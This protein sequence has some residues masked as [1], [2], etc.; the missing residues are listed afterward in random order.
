M[1]LP[2]LFDMIQYF[3]KTA[4]MV[5]GKSYRGIRLLLPTLCLL[6]QIPALFAQVN[7]LRSAQWISPGFAEKTDQ[8]P[9]VLF[10]KAFTS[11]KAVESAELI[12]TA[13]GIYDASINGKRVGDG[14]F[15]PGY[16]A[17]K[18]RLQYQTYDVKALLQKGGKDRAG[19]LIQVTV[20][21]GW[22]R[23]HFGNGGPKNNYGSDAS[24]LLSL[25]ITYTDGTQTTVNSDQSWRAGTGPILSSDLYDGETYDANIQPQN[26]QPVKVNITAFSKDNLVPTIGEAVKK[27]DVISAK[28]LL[29]DNVIDFQQ[30]LAGWVKFSVQ[31][32]KGD[33]V[34]IYH[35]ETLDKNGEFFT[36]NLRVAKATDT[37][38]LSG[39]GLETFEP[40]FT[41]HGFRYIKVSG[42][43]LTAGK[44]A[45][46]NAVV[47]GTQLKATGTFSCS[48]PKINQLQS[49]IEWSMRSNFFDIP[50]D[51]PQRSERLGWNE[52]A[53]VFAPTAS[54]L[55]DVKDFYRKWLFD[56]TAEQSPSGAVP[57]TV[58]VSWGDNT[59][60]YAGWGDAATKT[61]WT[62]YQRYG[63]TQVLKDQYNS[64]K[65]W[66][67]YVTSVSPDYLWKANGFG[68]WYPYG[69][70]TDLP[71][72]DQC[73][74][75]HSTQIMQQT[76][77]I[78]DQEDDYQKYTTLLGHI[79]T[80]FDKTYLHNIPNTQTAYVIGLHF[81]LLPK[82]KINNLVQLIASNNYHLATGFMGTPYLM[83]V[84]SENGQTELAYTLLYQ[85]GVPSWMYMLDKG[86][87]TMWE[88]WDAIQTNGDIQEMSLNHYAFGSIG[89]WL[90]EKVAGI[91]PAA[92]GYKKILIKPEPNEKLTWAKGSYKSSFGRI[93]SSWTLNGNDFALD[94]TI[95]PNT[96]AEID[97]PG[98]EPVF[99][100]PGTYH[101]SSVLKNTAEAIMDG[102]YVLYGDKQ[103]YVGRINA[104][105]NG[106]LATVDSF[107][108]ADRSK[109]VLK[110]KIDKHPEWDFE[111]QLKAKIDTPASVFNKLEK[112]SKLLV[113]SDIEGEFEPFRN[114]L[115]AN[116]VID[117]K[118]NWTFDSGAL[119]IAGDLFDRGKQVSQYLWLLYK[120]ESDAAAKGGSVHVI[121]GN[122]DIMNLGG[123]L[124]YVASVYLNNARLLGVGYE[125]F[126]SSQTELGRWLRSKNIA[127]KI[128][129]HLFVHGGIS[130]TLNEKNSSVQDINNQA[131]PYYDRWMQIQNDTTK[132]L[133]S[134][135]TSPFWYRGYFAE[136][137]ASTAQVD[138]TLKIFDVKK[139]IVGHTVNEHVASFY[140]GKVIGVDVD[141][142]DGQ[143][144]GLLIID[145]KFYRV[146]DKGNR[147]EL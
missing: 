8:R 140:D 104:T 67:D 127:E 22:W 143:H 14:Y 25:R 112:S 108:V 130:Q 58:P 65:A 35:A 110:V 18:K 114:L 34:R 79:K 12:I 13:H 74:W 144:E 98:K 131:R 103:A 121:L 23:G 6:F 88:K 44:L 28:A 40:H 119:V 42:V 120:L 84:L 72:L 41:Y 91:R 141:Q 59:R 48:D 115:V 19:N 137:L 97:V 96:S 105:D 30:N 83:H 49:N 75:Y 142:H 129:D 124:R 5:A 57:P 145:D 77:K 136:P 76:A 46:F 37:Y 33:T 43:K 73:Y 53:D 100:G 117:E 128:G 31:G 36:G 69:P 99:V 27:L 113:L 92:P 10:Q 80:A 3:S 32:K 116:K 62:I 2:K 87:T 15:R 82:E 107:A 118:Y 20:G 147:T 51:C 11:Y 47:L 122:H 39:K 86:A 138:S 102:P 55:M 52:D 24:L 50:T 71:Y 132:L 26:W 111:V 63:D 123:D 17:Y 109:Q 21:D 89:S 70:A 101:Y 38:I 1:P 78:L 7:P 85:T 64:M 139:I 56:L 29:P 9:P 134:G 45:D 16:T 146:D 61:P 68:D 133:F 125:F 54:Y 126:Y 60:A 93:S 66:V 94:V 90:Y 106:P 135:E 81:G 4:P 95:P